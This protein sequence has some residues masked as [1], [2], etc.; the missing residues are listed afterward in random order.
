MAS[1]VKE[2]YSNFETEGVLNITDNVIECVKL[3]LKNK[4]LWFE[5]KT[6]M[7]MLMR[8]SLPVFYNKFPR[9]VH[10]VGN[11]DD[12]QHLTNMLMLL[13]EVEN[14]KMAI[15]DAHKKFNEIN[16]NTYASELMKEIKEK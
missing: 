6:K 9:I 12:I 7:I 4:N 3:C 11:C 5:N 15:T 8:D 2:T 10:S 13:F 1:K 14:G 16:D